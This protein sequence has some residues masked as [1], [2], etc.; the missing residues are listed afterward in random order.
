MRH[1]PL[2]LRP[3]GALDLAPFAIPLDVTGF[4]DWLADAEAG[5]AV[6][7]YRGHLVFDRLPEKSGLSAQKRHA[8]ATVA[9]RVMSAAKNGFCFPVQRRLG[10]ND[11]LYIAVRASRLRSA[12][13]P[14]LRIAGPIA[15][16]AANDFVPSPVPLVAA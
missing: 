3:L 15:A 2:L 5:S 10:S 8:L 13:R 14:A 16:V 9:D 1:S 4:C 7:Y 6:A 11:W 12:S